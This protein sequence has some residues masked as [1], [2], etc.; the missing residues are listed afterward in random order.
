MQDKMQVTIM[1]LGSKGDGIAEINGE[2]HYI[3]YG[4]PGEVWELQ[5][6]QYS[7]R[8]MDSPDRVAPPCKHFGLCG[9]CVAQ[10]ME[11]K[12]YIK[13][14]QAG[15]VEAFKQRGIHPQIEPLR[16]LP[17]RSRRRASF[18]VECKKGKISIGFSEENKNTIIDVSDCHLLD[19]DITNILEV[20]KEISVIV[21][22][23]NSSGR[24][25]VTKLDIGLDVD[26]QNRFKQLLPN[27]RAEIFRI[28]EKKDIIRLTISGDIILMRANPRL[29]F[30]GIEVDIPSSVF[31]QPVP[32]AE[33]LMV[34]FVLNSIPKKTKHVCDLF[35]GVGTFTFHLAKK[36]L[37]SAFDNDRRAVA[38]LQQGAK[39]SQGLKPIQAYFR[40][41]FREPLSAKELDIFDV[42]LLDPPRIG[43][44]QQFHQLARSRVPLIIAVSCSPSTLARDARIIL[45]AG[46]EIGPITCVDQFIYS[47]HLE[48]MTV[49]K[50]KF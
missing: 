18:R 49:F 28:S 48:I 13:W 30:A 31:V 37:V 3:K 29:S 4:L 40:D 39:R 41:L 5:S 27:E 15:V 22:S 26:F 8:H 38:A 10:H 33:K 21:M 35:C 43:A 20:L 46:Y 17:S 32:A 1:E 34:E 47:P 14:K 42:V 45:N 25:V 23:D 50:K 11:E 9:G 2:K 6:D 16:L 44:A 7:R 12:L 36:V 24:I 19:P